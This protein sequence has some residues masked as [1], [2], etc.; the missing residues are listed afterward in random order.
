MTARRS[1]L[2]SAVFGAWLVGATAGFAPLASA[3]PTE[4]PA[5]PNFIDPANSCYYDLTPP[6][7]V[8]LPGGAKAVTATMVTTRCTGKAAS[9]N[10]VVC[11]ATP[12]GPGQCGSEYNWAPAQVFVTASRYE[13]S[14]TAKGAGCWRDLLNQFQE[15]CRTVDPVTTTL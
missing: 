5:D 10:L 3:E 4:P 12:E 2:A 15:K 1:M 11:V 7:L 9:T 14:F 13:G 6:S 8:E